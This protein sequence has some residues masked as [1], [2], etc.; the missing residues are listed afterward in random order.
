LC[1]GI[2]EPR[3]PHLLSVTEARPTLPIPLPSAVPDGLRRR[4]ARFFLRWGRGAEAAS[5]L[6][7]ADVS[8]RD[9]FDRCRALVAA[10]ELDTARELAREL[11]NDPEAGSWGHRA[12]GEV[13]LAME[14]PHRADERFRAAGD[15]VG[16]ARAHLMLGEPLRALDLLRSAEP[17]G[18]ETERVRLA[19]L[20]AL[21]EETDLLESRLE[22]LYEEELR[23]L[24]AETAAGEPLGEPTDDPERL[25]A[26][27][28][29]VFGYDAFR[30]GQ[31][32]VLVPLMRGE[33]VLGMM[34][35]GAGKSI[36][37]QLPAALLPGATV[38][39]SPLI[40]LMKD[41]VEGLPP[42]LYHRA[43]LINSS[44]PA[45]EAERRME[46]LARGEYSLVYAAPERLRQWPF[47]RALQRRGVSLFVID[48]AHCVSLWGHDFRPDYFFI[49]QSLGD[50]G[51]PA[52]LALTATATPDMQEEI[53]RQLGV[54][55]RRVNLGTF[56]PNLRFAVR[57]CAGDAEK[58]A[59]LLALLREEPGPAIVYVD[60]RKLAEEL[61]VKLQAAGIQ[62]EAYHAGIE[63]V[64][65]DRVQSRFMLGEVR[66]MT[67]T[68]A[69][70]MGV[71]KADVRVVAHYNLS[72]S[73][74]AY[75]QEAGRAGR[76]GLPARC[77]LL[78][79]SFDRSNLTR[80]ATLD[81]LSTGEM[82]TLHRALERVVGRSD[83]PISADELARTA[84]LDETRVRVGISLLQS[85]G[86][87]ERGYDLPVGA[88]V[89]RTRREP[90][91]DGEGPE[92][93]RRALAAGLLPS[94]GGT[95][96]L[97]AQKLAV[98]A[99]VALERLEPLLTEWSARG[100]LRARVGSRAMGI[101]LKG[102]P[103]VEKAI[104]GALEQIANMDFRRLKLL[105]EYLATRECRQV[106]VSRYFGHDASPCGVC[107][108]CA[109]ASR[110]E[111]VQEPRAAYGDGD[112]H[113]FE[114]LRAWRRE[115][116][117]EEGIPAYAVFH[118]RVLYEVAQAKPR[119]LQALA[120]VSGVG[121]T[122]LHAYGDEVVSLIRRSE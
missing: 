65:R 62:A 104:S 7:P 67:A 68:I 114:L 116:A 39:I 19:I 87:V 58:W 122:K 74:E 120:E 56:R 37:F 79:T 28:K 77:V 96:T 119:S 47:I 21:G 8:P 33:S 23:D 111:T 18:A 38:V 24:E 57:R 85:I 110:G 42:S 91:G 103:A 64:E 72:R 5:V 35:T 11:V 59:A 13:F 76:D 17:D 69:F 88:W 40:A 48:E 73:L 12:V 66:V 44:L 45:G 1:D 15:P 109:A 86:A 92:A 22:D 32:E 115:K 89:A 70:G 26:A 117:R 118:D 43:T 83:D 46:A 80:R 2:G 95:M 3:S 99:G 105:S 41:Q 101:R 112:S 108:T 52:V 54:E 29:R 78:Y 51:R 113:L 60:R 34:P 81:R 90:E 102:I 4:T 100:W 53:G 27:L 94:P 93:L 98:A 49:R 121:R 20:R 55:L 61:A 10:G 31:L 14:K 9:R 84:G 75:Y 97:P 71:D 63:R 82:L 6:P 30:D 36:C 50:V 16:R 107:D 106:F 25:T